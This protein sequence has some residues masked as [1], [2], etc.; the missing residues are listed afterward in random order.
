M[1]DSFATYPS[2]AGKTALVTGG[3]SGI[4]AE[5]VRAFAA[6]GTRVGF[7]DLD[8]NASA[9]I[10]AEQTPGTP[11]GPVASPRRCGHGDG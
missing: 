3:A 10:A 4:G 5:I 8:E 11:F 6:Q 7:I 9:A 2:L 1:A